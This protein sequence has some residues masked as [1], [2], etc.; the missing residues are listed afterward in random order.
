[1]PSPFPACRHRHDDAFLQG[2]QGAKCTCSTCRQTCSRTHP[3]QDIRAP[4]GGPWRA[5]H[6]AFV[7]FAAGNVL[8]GLEVMA[9]RYRNSAGERGAGTWVGV[10]VC[11]VCAEH[12][13]GLRGPNPEQAGGGQ[14]AWPVLDVSHQGDR[15][16]RGQ[17]MEDVQSSEGRGRAP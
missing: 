16:K 1:M 2:S 9:M 13:W 4:D 12:V 11:G 3:H 14:L 10:F 6:C 8:E 15:G 7:V 17:G 5:L